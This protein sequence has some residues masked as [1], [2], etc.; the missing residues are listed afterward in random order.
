MS[1]ILLKFVDQPV[2]IL[3]I[4]DNDVCNKWLQLLQSNMFRNGIPIFRDPKKYTKKYL[5][6]LIDLA[7][8][9][10]NWDFV[11]QINSLADTTRL[12]KHIETNLADGFA[13]IP[14][15]HDN[16]YHELHYALHCVERYNF[17]IPTVTSDIQVEWFNNDGHPLDETF[18]HQLMMNF[19]DIR[20]QNPYVGHMPMQ[21][22]QQH[23]TSNISQTCKFHDF[24]RPGF[25]IQTILEKQNY[26]FSIS[27]YM[28]WWKTNAPEF[29]KEKTIDRILHYTGHPV[30]GHVENLDDL[31]QVVSSQHF[32]EFQD[33]EIIW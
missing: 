18:N 26:N 31:Q 21:I 15:E 33:M 24:V 23:D 2:L 3:K 16:L 30:I 7:N 29:V 5:A 17:N 6:H 19:G 28:A 1:R 27:E 22:W 4:N 20:L 32:L 9:N 8:K 14:E 12:H 25:R 10:L 13:C 11:N